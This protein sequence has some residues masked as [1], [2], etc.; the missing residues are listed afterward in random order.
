MHSVIS[1][2]RVETIIHSKPRDRRL[3]IEEAAGLGKHRKRRRR[4]ELKLR[5]TRDNLDRALDVEREA[6]ARLRPLKR[7]AQAA[8]I[9]ARI[10]REETVTEGA[11][12]L[13][14]APLRCR[15]GLPAAAKAAAA[16]RGG[17]GQ[18]R[19]AAGRG[20]QTALGRR[21]ALRRA[22]PGPDPGLGRPDQAA[23]RVRSGSRCEWRDSRAQEAEVEARLERLRAELGPLTLEVAEG[24][25]RRS[26]RGSWRRSWGRSTPGLAAAL[27]GPGDG[28]VTTGPAR[29]AREGALGDVRTGSRAGDP[30]RAPGRGPARRA[31]P[32]EDAGA[33]GGRR[34]AAR[35][36]ARRARRRSSRPPPRCT[37]GWN[38][39]SRRWSATRATATR[40]ADELRACSKR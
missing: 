31:P 30:P 24:S 35:G 40:I 11:D 15:P 2:G 29:S 21:G 19:G 32:G 16:A 34:G 7:Q 3:L 10:D 26:A 8:E 27:A 36:R 4:A 5:G 1:Q 39:P 12:R 37:P 17:A 33:P 20:E 14:G 22:R 18:A 23:R 38:G 28:A 6:R 13:R 9:G 25:A